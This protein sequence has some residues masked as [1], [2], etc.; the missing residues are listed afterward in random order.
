[1]FKFWTLCVLDSPLGGGLK[2]TYT[3]HLRLI[4]QLVEDFLFVH[5]KND[6]KTDIHRTVSANK[7]II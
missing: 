7:F 6:T 5:G 3:V 4:G 2:G 1:L